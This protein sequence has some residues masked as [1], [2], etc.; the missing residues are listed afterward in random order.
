MPSYGT[1]LKEIISNKRKLEEHEHVALTEE[2]SVAIQNK[3]PAKPKYPNSSSIPCLIG[4]IFDS[5]SIPYLIG[6][7]SIDDSLCDLG[8]NVCLIPFSLYKKLEIGKMRCTTI[9]LQLADRTVKYPMG[10]LEAVHIKVGDLYALVDFVILK[11][12]KDTR[13]PIILVRPF[14]ATAR[15]HI[16][17]KNGKLLLSHKS[18]IVLIIILIIL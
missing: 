2:C 10:G 7:M 4:N 6:N 15:S 1:L 16:D 13:T 3:L 9:S 14:L 5:F 12:E 11:N 17:V 18:C 8:P